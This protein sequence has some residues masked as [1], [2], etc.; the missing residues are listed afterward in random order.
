ML[1]IALQ[2]ECKAQREDFCL[3]LRN[4][5]HLQNVTSTQLT[6]TY[7]WYWYVKV[8]PQRE[9]TIYGT[10]LHLKFCIYT[11]KQNCV[12][13]IIEIS[14][15]IMLVGGSLQFFCRVSGPL[16]ALGNRDTIKYVFL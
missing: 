5:T 3:T 6:R 12:V 1:E 4:L 9:S 10:Q 7:V 14:G 15:N 16:P 13:G 2:K 8:G 11:V